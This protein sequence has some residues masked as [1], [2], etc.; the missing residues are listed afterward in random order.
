M[1][2]TLGKITI[3]FVAILGIAGIGYGAHQSIKMHNQEQVESTKESLRNS[4]ESKSISEDKESSESRESSE[5]AQS[6]LSN[7]SSSTDTETS[8]NIET[9]YGN[10]YSDGAK[11]SE[12]YEAG[13][14]LDTEYAK[15]M[16]VKY[17]ADYK[18]G[19]KNSGYYDGYNND[20]PVLTDNADY[21]AGWH[22]GNKDY[23]ND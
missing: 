1:N 7:Q 15:S 11:S 6:Q 8:R 9:Y 14:S 12:A 4:A 18:L 21:M 19:I 13:Y 22:D 17:N 10:D 20:D 2:S 3:A 5:K 23:M 16:N